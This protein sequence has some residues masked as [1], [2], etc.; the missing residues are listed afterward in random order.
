[1]LIELYVCYVGKGGRG[2]DKRIE[3]RR[4]RNGRGRR[5][6]SGNEGQEGCSKGGCP[7]NQQV[8]EIDRDNGCPRTG[9][10]RR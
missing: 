8:A 5:K 3:G 9:F 10:A 4:R 6:S 7:Y 2:R 1:M